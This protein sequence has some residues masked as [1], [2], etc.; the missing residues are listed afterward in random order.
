MDVDH[1][2]ERWKD[3]RIGFHQADINTHLQRFWPR[4]VS[5]PL[6]AAPSLVFV[7]L[8]GKSLDMIWLR[9]QGHDVLGIELSPI[10]VEDFFREND[11]TPTITELSRPDDC[12][13]PMRRFEAEGIT[14][15]EGDIFD[16]TAE[17]LAGVTQVFDRAS[18]VALPLEMRARYVTHMQDILPPAIPTLLV[19]ME[20]DQSQMA[21]PPFAV[22]EEEVRTLY[23]ARQQIR[24]V[25][26]Q[27][28][29]EE[30]PRFAE[31]GVTRLDEKVYL[32]RDVLEAG[33]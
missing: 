8:C 30:S 27:D 10:A 32:L 29:L 9:D 31:R 4:V 21:G 12:H 28:L 11:L 6:S 15:L 33:E 5:V 13:A 7:P 16:L 2:L 17:D 18:L 24:L 1:W 22:H 23:G 20:Y 14:V 25:H 19:T 3:N 26:T